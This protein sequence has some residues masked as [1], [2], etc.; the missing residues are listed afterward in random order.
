MDALVLPDKSALP[1]M[2]N[3]SGDFDIKGWSPK[4]VKEIPM[5]LSFK[6]GSPTWLIAKA[7]AIV[8]TANE[9]TE[10]DFLRTQ[11]TRLRCIDEKLASLHNMV[12]EMV[13]LIPMNAGVGFEVDVNFGRK[14]VRLS[15]DQV[16]IVNDI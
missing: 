5:S 2:P 4:E 3:G 8:K 16:E 13:Q 14:I 10:E 9:Y 15:K 11:P 7:D 1:D 12:G 6:G